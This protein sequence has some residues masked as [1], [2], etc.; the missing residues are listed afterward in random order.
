MS[1]LAKGVL[2]PNKPAAARAQATP[3]FVRDVLTVFLL[4]RD[5]FAGPAQQGHG[6]E[7]THSLLSAVF[8]LLEIGLGIRLGPE[9]DLARLLDRAVLALQ[10]LLAVQTALDS[11]AFHLDADR[12]P[13][14]LFALD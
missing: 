12:I 9:S 7:G 11:L 14:P 6:V 1:N 2:A 3:L 10:Q 8:E 13:F 4:R 5:R